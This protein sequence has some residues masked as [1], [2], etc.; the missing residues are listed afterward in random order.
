MMLTYTEILK[1]LSTILENQNNTELTA[2]NI[3]SETGKPIFD[4]ILFKKLKKWNIID[5]NVLDKKTRDSDIRLE[6]N[7]RFIFPVYKN[8]LYEEKNEGKG[9]FKKFFLTQ[10]PIYFLNENVNYLYM[11]ED[12]TT[13]SGEDFEEFSES[14]VKS[15][16]LSQE[17]RDPERVFL[18]YKDK[19]SVAF[20]KFRKLLFQDD[21]LIICKY[22]G[23]NE[24]LLIG[25]KE[26]DFMHT[27]INT[28]KSSFHH[29]ETSKTKVST[30]VNIQST[31]TVD[32][33]NE[34]IRHQRMFLGAPGIGKSFAVKNESS[35]IFNEENITTVTFHPGFKY[36][37]FIGAYKPLV[38]DGN[39]EYAFQPGIFLTKLINAIK[40]PDELFLFVIEEINRGEAN[41]IFGDFFQL[42]ERKNNGVSRY[43]L[44][45][46]PDIHQY[47]QK[48]D[49]FKDGKI[50]LPNNLHLW[51]TCNLNDQHTVS[52]DNSFI[53]RWD[54]RFIHIDHYEKGADFTITL[55]TIDEPVPWNII[56]K[57]INDELMKFQSIQEDQLIGPFFIQN[58]LDAEEFFSNVVVHLKENVLQEMSGQMFTSTFLSP[59]Y[60]SYKK[61]EDIFLSIKWD[62]LYESN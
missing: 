59:L 47:L 49:I 40:N 14:T 23:S 50:S 41:E 12:S 46:G 25:A 61:G 44:D 56:R 31:E 16:H 26:D 22:Y 27:N 2:E 24:Y 45:V 38:V 3:Y 19:D 18:G 34:E 7:E 39:I 58:D 8:F 54:R 5:E 57:K 9:Y 15:V 29:L 36:S 43:S 53:R 20:T 52:M 60:D 62:D 28:S 33:L 21:F 6:G 55:P 35:E 17:S 37:H 1:D 4:S 13:F 42:L 10:I 48:I 11:R 32:V 30:S 51:A